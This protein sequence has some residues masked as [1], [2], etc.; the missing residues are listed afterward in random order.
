LANKTSICLAAFA[1]IFCFYSGVYSRDIDLD[2]I[3]LN[4]A[5]PFY[6]R[7]LEKKITAYQSV[8]SQLIDRDICFA[9][10]KDGF[11]IIYIK[12]FGDLNILYSYNRDTQTQ[13][14]LLRLDGTITAARNSVNGRFVFIKRLLRNGNTAL[15]GETIVFDTRSKTT[16]KLESTY[17]FIDFSLSSSGNEILYETG[18]GIVEFSPDTLNKNIIVGR[19]EYSDIINPNSPTIAFLS[20]NRKK[21][22]LVNGSGGSY[23]AKI[24]FAKRSYG[25]SGVSSSSEI[26]WI[27]NNQVAYRK[28]D[29]GNYTIHIY[30]VATQRSSVLGGRSLNTNLQYSSLSKIV[31]FLQDQVIQLYDLRRN[32]VLMIGLEGEDV[33]FS[34]DGS[35]FISLYLK[36]LFMSNLNQIKRKNLELIKNSIQIKELY[37][38]LLDTKADWSNEYSPEYLR[39]KISVYGKL[40]E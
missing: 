11:N 30:D 22:L 36:K 31:C 1:S 5:S 19:K 39:K 35:R 8:N 18:R 40:T 6:T 29:A 33:F 16:T 24:I 21:I 37:K 12:E 14:E 28:G 3:Y 10:W 27:N 20:P 25:L 7:L 23:K 9:F 4:N 38:T 13:V 26:F 15:S 17:P 2:A 32:A 34:P